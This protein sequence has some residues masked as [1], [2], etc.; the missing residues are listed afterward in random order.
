MQSFGIEYH[1][2]VVE[3]TSW[4]EAVAYCTEK[5]ESLLSVKSDAIWISFY[6]SIMVDLFKRVDIIY[7][8]LS[9]STQHG[10]VR[11]ICTCICV[12]N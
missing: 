11:V 1:V 10:E 9:K 6:L 12:F 8:G 5:G 2:Y 7:I 3:N 4:D